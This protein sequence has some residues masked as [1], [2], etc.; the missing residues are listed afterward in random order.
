MDECIGILRELE[1]IYARLNQTQLLAGILQRQGFCELIRGNIVSARE[2]LHRALARQPH[3]LF[4]YFYLCKTWLY[5]QDPEGLDWARALVEE[6]GANIF[7]GIHKGTPHDQQSPPGYPVGKLAHRLGVAERIY[8]AAG[9]HHEFRDQVLAWQ[10]RLVERF[11]H[12]EMQWLFTEPLQREEIEPVRKFGKAWTFDP[13]SVRGRIHQRKGIWIQAPTPLG[14]VDKY[15]TPRYSRLVAGDFVLQVTTHGGEEVIADLCTPGRLGAK[16]RRRRQGLGA[17]GL[18]VLVDGVMTFRMVVHIQ[19]PGEVLCEIYHQGVPRT[20]GRGVLE[21][22]PVRL[23]LER[24]NDMLF[25]YASNDPGPW[26]LAGR[27]TFPTLPVTV[28]FHGQA[29]VDR[30]MVTNGWKVR[31]GEVKLSTGHPR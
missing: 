13:G 1:E 14:G 15:T 29:L 18:H 23:R 21:D 4:S 24:K 10:A 27:S 25:A 9:V 11:S 12:L 19:S 3:D 8:R 6:V 26:F 31:F 2:V 7:D 16:Q 20:L 28:G 30:Y 17:G 5:D 22:G